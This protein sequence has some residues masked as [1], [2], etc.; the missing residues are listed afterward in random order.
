MLPVTFYHLA[1]D[2]II[3]TRIYDD[4]K[5]KNNLTY[6]NLPIVIE[7]PLNDDFSSVNILLTAIENRRP[8]LKKLLSTNVKRIINPLNLI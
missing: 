3:L 8:I 6:I 2:P 7:A 4:D 5:D 1:I